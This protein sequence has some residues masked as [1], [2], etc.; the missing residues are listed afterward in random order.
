MG[1]DGCVW[2]Y[3]HVI[4]REIGKMNKGGAHTCMIW[5][6]GW[7]GNFPGHHVLTCMTQKNEKWVS[8]TQHMY[9]GPH[10]AWIQLK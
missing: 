5:G 10:N 9:Q 4:T 3:R 8:G 1:A 7:P 6:S 2:A